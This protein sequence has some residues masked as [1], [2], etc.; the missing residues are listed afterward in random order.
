VENQPYARKMQD[1][2]ISEIETNRPE[3]VVYVN[4]ELSWLWAPNYDHRILD[5]WRDYWTRNLELISAV[6]IKQPPDENSATPKT[7]PV[8]TQN[9][10]TDHKSW[11]C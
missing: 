6:P 10:T 2:M 4:D 9:S 7:E 3:Y 5:W 1:Q 11:C 8:P